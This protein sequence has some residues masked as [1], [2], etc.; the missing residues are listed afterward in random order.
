MAHGT[1]LPD[2]PLRASPLLEAVF[3]RSQAT[4]E[5]IGKIEE[6][7]MGKLVDT[8]RRSLTDAERKVLDM[9]FGLDDASQEVSASFAL[10]RARIR[11]IE[12]KALRK[13]RAGVERLSAG[14]VPS[15]R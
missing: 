13:L 14:D 12:E 9:R 15:E 2:T 3:E 11:E 5:G 6:R 1:K 8:M 7:S 10:T 4:R